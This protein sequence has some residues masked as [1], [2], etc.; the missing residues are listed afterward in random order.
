VL[1][2]KAPRKGQFQYGNR[3]GPGR[4]LSDEPV[5]LWIGDRNPPP[6]PGDWTDSGVDALAMLEYEMRLHELK[7]FGSWQHKI[8]VSK[9]TFKKIM[10]VWKSMRLFDKRATI[11]DAWQKLFPGKSGESEIDDASRSVEKG[12]DETD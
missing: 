8:V 7:M 6:K 4:P 10:D 2:K 11:Y 3:G 5:E 12:T 9:R 1:K